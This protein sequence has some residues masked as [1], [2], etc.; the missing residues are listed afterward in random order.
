VKMLRNSKWLVALGVTVLAFGLLF[1]TAMADPGDGADGSSNMHEQMDPEMYGQMIQRMTEVHG[2][3]FTAE[4]L[5]RMNE[6]GD[7][8]GDGQG[9]MGAGM[10]N[11]FQGMMDGGYG[12]GSMMGQG[13]DGTVGSMMRGVQGLMHGFSNGGMMGGDYDNGGMMNGGMMGR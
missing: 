1:G 6:G 5:Q 2:A 8:H 11:G 13:F 9:M 4:M 3:E 10:M 12:S 7:C